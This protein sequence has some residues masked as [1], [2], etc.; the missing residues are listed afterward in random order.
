MIT[1]LLSLIDINLNKIEEAVVMEFQATKSRATT[2]DKKVE[3]YVNAIKNLITMMTT[4]VNKELKK[5]SNERDDKLIKDY[6]SKIDDHKKKLKSLMAQSAYNGRLAMAE[7]LA[8]VYS[9][10][11]DI[12]ME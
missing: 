9:S 10:L 3:N 4:T 12:I 8:I 11:D 1:N 5:P 6:Q 7:S 2:N